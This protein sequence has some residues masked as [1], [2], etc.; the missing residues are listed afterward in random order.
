MPPPAG[1]GKRQYPACMDFTDAPLYTGHGQ[2]VIRENTMHHH[3]LRGI[4]L[5]L[6]FIAVLPLAALARQHRLYDVADHNYPVPA[7]NVLWVAADAAAD[8]DGS[9]D[10]P[11][12]TIKAALDKARDGTTLI[13][14]SGIYR[15]PH[16]FITRNRITLQAEPHGDV[17]LKGSDVVPAERF[18]KEGG[19]WKVTGDF[20]NFCH[21]CTV[22]ANPSKEGVAAYP[23]QVFIDDRPLTQVGSKAE[24]KAG[25]FYVEDQTPTTTVE[26]DN[27]LSGYRLGAQDAITYYLGSDPNGH[28]V[29]ISERARAFTATGKHLTVRGI[30]IA[31]YAP[32][33]SWGLKGDPRLGDFS[34]PVALSINGD[35]SRMEDGIVAQNSNTALFVDKARRVR[36]NNIRAIDNGATAIGMNRAHGSSIENS[37]F[38]NNNTAGNLMADC[39]AYCTIGHAKITHAR[40]TVFRGNIVDDSGDI[41]Y[42]PPGYW[43]DEGCINTKI[44]NNFFTGVSTAMMYEVCDSGIL[45]S[46]IVENSDS[47]IYLAGSSNSRIY[48][49]TFSHVFNPLNL[50]EEPRTGG[51]NYYKNGRCLSEEPWSKEQG[52]SW[53]TTGLQVYNNILSSRKT[54]GSET[55]RA[56]L[57]R[58]EGYD[59]PD[60]G[61]IY[62]NDMFGG[63][64]YNA[65]Y[66]RGLAREPYLMNWDLADV[67]GANNLRFM[68]TSDIAA[69][70]QVNKKINGLERHALDLF[71]SPAD[72]PYFTREAAGSRQS[73]YRLRA[74]S[75]AKGSGKALPLDIARA[76]DPG[77]NQVKS[78]VA[79]DRGALLNA[80]MDAGGGAAAPA[81]AAAVTTAHKDASPAAARR[82]AAQNAASTDGD[83]AAGHATALP[84][85]LSGSAAGGTGGGSA[86]G[87]ALAGNGGTDG[88]T[89]TVAADTRHMQRLPDKELPRYDRI[90]PYS[91]GFAAVEKNGRWGFIDQKGRE[92]VRPQYQDVLAY[93]EARAA[94]KKDGRWGFIDTKGKE[95]V[96]PEYDTVWPYKDGRATVQKDGERRL[97]DLDG[98]AVTP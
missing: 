22:N 13:L 52:L 47:G 68:R 38:R 65:Y 77:G 63:L 21:V 28:S 61:R 6:L 81:R 71:G 79:V 89:A 9:R 50:K 42:R 40:D 24:V 59:D 60:G 66:R 96:K 32:H 35:D 5:P 15:E 83:H 64:D 84:Y 45:A 30:N 48:N 76:I 95:T 39:G 49:N 46:N 19:L 87:Q 20:Q 51:C 23:E 62:S 34:G 58:T 37:Y 17:W 69:A 10:K 91:E 93:G 88:M 12:R 41:A 73:N 74:D 98:H 14:K 97:L 90:R 33:Q 70:R 18:E 2:T 1:R 29:E 26:P 85:S 27:N 72:N 55:Y 8:G 57:V 4:R 82:T 92:T 16:F 75:P 7:A 11:Y 31:H 3:T 80:L 94:V 25:T 43:C 56:I 54:E 78:G 36:L 86:G 44:T 67:A 53:D